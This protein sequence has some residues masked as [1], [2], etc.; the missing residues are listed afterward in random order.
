MKRSVSVFIALALGI[1]A[2]T[3]IPRPAMAADVTLYELTENMSI[4]LDERQQ[5]RTATSALTGW[6]AVGTPLCPAALVAAYGPAASACVVNA[7][8]SDRVNTRT[9]QG[10]FEGT[11]TVVVPGDNPVDGAEL[12]AMKGRF[13]GKMDFAP[14]LLN[15]VPYG[16]VKGTMK[17]AK[18]DDRISFTGVFRLP[19]AGNYAGPETGGATLRQI[20]CPLTLSANPY[21]AL[22]DGWDLVYISTSNGVPNGRCV[23]IG[24]KEMSLGTSLVRFEITFGGVQISRDY[25]D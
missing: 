11:L 14:A 12:V 13:R 10:E 2:P 21:T 3:S 9:G 8:G 24:P 25:D 5:F 6:A 1:V 23:D 7:N 4:L 16:T 18:G 17:L 22:Y 15:G 19:F 20:F